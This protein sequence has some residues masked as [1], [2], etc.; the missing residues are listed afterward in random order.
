MNMSPTAAR[1][2]TP[3]VAISLACAAAL[4]T[5]LLAHSPGPPQDG[6]PSQEPFRT[7]VDLVHLDVTVLDSRQ[8]PVRGLTAD[9]FT[10]LEDREPQSVLTFLPVDV[11]APAAPRAAWMHDVPDEIASN[12]HDSRR[13]VV[14]VMDDAL[15]GYAQGEPR[16]AR[17]V[18]HAAIDELG[19]GDLAAVVFTFRGRAQNFTTDR[20]LLRRAV[21]SYRSRRSPETGPPLACEPALRR[22]AVETLENVAAALRTAPPG[23]KLVVF[24][25]SAGG[26]DVRTDPF[27]PL[28]RVQ[29]MF[30]AIQEA[31][32][33]VN[34]FNPAGLQTY[35]PTAADRSLT[36][37]QGR[38]AARRQQVDELRALAEN[39]GGR[40][41][42]D[43]NAPEAHVPAVF[44]QSRSYYLLGFQSANKKQDGRFRRVRVQVNRPGVTVRTRS[45]YFAPRPS[46]ARRSPDLPRSIDAA[47]GSG[48]PVQDVP[49]RIQVAAF[50]VPGVR[51]A[52]VTVTSGLTASAEGWSVAVGPVELVT[53]VF[54]G[55]LRPRGRFQ[56]TIRLPAPSGAARQ[57]HD[58]HS[59]LPLRPGRYE[60]RVAV[61]HGGRAGSV[62][63]NVD[64]PDF[65]K[66]DLALSDLVL[67]RPGPPASDGPLAG[68][69]PVEPTTARTFDASDRVT[70]FLR[71]YQPARAGE[72]PLTM[73]TRILDEADTIVFQRTDHYGAGTAGDRSIDHQLE[74]PLAQLRAGSYLLILE[75]PDGRDSLR[76]TARFTV[77]RSPEPFVRS[78]SKP[79]ADGTRVSESPLARPQ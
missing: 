8:R 36:E 2:W 7:G 40:T 33:T 24:I 45:G 12:E 51:E 62:F 4:A 72:T 3:A 17:A 70:A 47:L 37:A 16:S 1:R 13:F 50:A 66:A 38:I 34:V 65:A 61:E 44:E 74:L 22:C 15:T 57:V 52:A 23:R 56:Q 25:G 29:D 27:S 6:L 35:G 77:T 14:I 68:L 78:G 42:V 71:I 43:T 39:T 9:D 30:R 76:R 10:I 21:D 73:A 79:R 49:I 53:A 20:S 31:N 64:V 55:D 28:S 11:P 58:V 26:L 46:D 63:V 32:V 19:P 48:V 54:D 60:I 69:L 59:R 5:G 18:A 75:A 67:A 41:F